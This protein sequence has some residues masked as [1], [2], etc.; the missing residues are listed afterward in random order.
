M[1]ML[2]S[3]MVVGI[4]MSI[5]VPRKVQLQVLIPVQNPSHQ[6][7]PLSLLVPPHLLLSVVVLRVLLYPFL[8]LYVPVHGIL[9]IVGNGS[10]WVFLIY[11]PRV[12]VSIDRV[13]VLPM[14]PLLGV[15]RWI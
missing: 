13:L 9:S 6:V 5:M 4:V 10:V 8:P 15:E 11:V 14:R 3:Q 7:Q 2:S 1:H 12:F